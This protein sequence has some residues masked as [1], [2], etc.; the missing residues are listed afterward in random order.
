MNVGSNVD[1]D[2]LSRSLKSIR[3]NGMGIMMSLRS[4]EDALQ[5]EVDEEDIFKKPLRSAVHCQLS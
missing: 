4:L 3:N 5:D 2:G 1:S